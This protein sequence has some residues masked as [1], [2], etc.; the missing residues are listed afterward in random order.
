MPS[1]S[2]RNTSVA[3]PSSRPHSSSSG[4]PR[5]RHSI[6]IAT[7]ILEHQPPG[8]TLLPIVWKHPQGKGECFQ[9]GSALRGYGAGMGPQSRKRGDAGNV[10]IN[11]R[12]LP[13]S[14][15][16]KIRKR[17]R[18]RFSTRMTIFRPFGE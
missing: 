15:I 13:S 9:T 5:S 1:L 8:G 7:P 2:T 3:V 11:V 12:S 4:P 6:G 10:A 17:S 16:L 14:R 18:S